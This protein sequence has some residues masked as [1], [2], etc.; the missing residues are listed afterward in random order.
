MKE[1]LEYGNQSKRIVDL[2]IANHEN[3]INSMRIMWAL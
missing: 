3:W 1:M 2:L